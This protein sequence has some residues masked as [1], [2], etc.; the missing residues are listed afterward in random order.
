[1]LGKHKSSL[2]IGSHKML[3]YPERETAIEWFVCPPRL[4]GSLN[5][6]STKI[7]ISSLDCRVIKSETHNT[8]RTIH[9]TNFSHMVNS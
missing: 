1:M 4:E 7:K 2:P 6:A 5:R 8:G 9:Y 3:N